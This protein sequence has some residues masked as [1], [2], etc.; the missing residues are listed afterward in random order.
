MRIYKDII[1]G[2]E[3]FSVSYKMK[4]VDEALY[5]VTGRLVQRDSSPRPLAQ[6]F[7]ARGWRWSGGR[8][9]RCICLDRCGDRQLIHAPP[10][11]E[12]I[13]HRTTRV[14]SHETYGTR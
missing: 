8:Q 12:L 2:V 10:R 14:Q 1:T 3:M 11:W 6:L 9:R 7:L 13:H 4:L 5:E